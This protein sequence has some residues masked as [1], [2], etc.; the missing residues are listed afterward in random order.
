MTKDDGLLYNFIL[1]GATTV[2]RIEKSKEY[3]VDS[4]Q[5]TETTLRGVVRKSK[6]GKKKVSEKTYHPVIDFTRGTYVC[7]CEDHLFQKV[8]CKHL[9]ALLK[10]VIATKGKRKRFDAFMLA[11]LQG[12]SET[13]MAEDFISTGV[14]SMDALMFG[15]FPTNVVTVLTGPY[16]KGK[17]WLAFQTAAHNAANGGKS[18]YVEA[19]KVYT[20]KDR[21]ARMLD[22]FGKRYETDLRKN[23]TFSFP[24]DL[25][26][27]CRQFGLDLKLTFK[28]KYV[29][30]NIDPGP[31][32][33]FPLY[34]IVK[35]N[36]YNLVVIDSMTK[37]MKQLIP[38][39][40]N[41][42]RGPRAGVINMLYGR[43]EKLAED[44]NCAV[45]LIS[46][47]SQAQ[48]ATRF[49]DP[50]GNVYGG[51]TIGF[52]LKYCVQIMPAGKSHLTTAELDRGQVPKRFI[53]RE[54]VAEVK[55]EI[56]VKVLLDYGYVDAK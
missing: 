22:I 23:L 26:A 49:E 7:T 11:Y 56:I 13:A 24:S 35:E 9:I 31:H 5:S 18:L 30:A 20:R 53:R 10:K 15:G 45:I 3:V 55:D 28:D 32:E 51:T 2:E 40:P 41:Q 34:N 38:V 52:N 36:G 39:P 29:E 12:P 27:L 19:E 16:K 25:Y 44:L 14:E 21:Q 1:N 17:T 48:G 8:I 54:W 50:L 42:N 6:K 46:H 43:M 47:L 4:V 33:A 37:P